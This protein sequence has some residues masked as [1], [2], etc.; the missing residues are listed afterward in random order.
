[1]ATLLH[2]N[3]ATVYS[4]GVDG[5][6]VWYTM[7]YLEGG[8]LGGAAPLRIRDVVET[9][10]QVSRAL[11]HM[12]RR[13]VVHRD[14]KPSNIHLKRDLSGRID[15]ATLFDFGIATTL[16][17]TRRTEIGTF[18][19]TLG[20]SAP[21]LIDGARPSPASDQYALACTAFELL[22]GS[23]PFPESTTTAIVAAHSAAP[24]PPISE[25]GERFAAL[26]AVFHRALAKKPTARYPSCSAFASAMSAALLRETHSIDSAHPSE[27]LPVRRS[28]V[29]PA[30]SRDTGSSP[31]S[32]VSAK[33]YRRRRLIFGGL[34]V[35]IVAFISVLAAAQ[36]RSYTQT[37]ESSSEVS[38][39]SSASS[40]G[41]MG[42]GADQTV[43]ARSSAVRGDQVQGAT[44]STGPSPM[45]T[46]ETGSA[47][48]DQQRGPSE[49]GGSTEPAVGDESTSTNNRVWGLLLDPNGR[50]YAA[51]RFR[52]ADAMLSEVRARWGYDSAT[53]K[54]LYFTEGC[55]AFAAGEP[56]PRSTAQVQ[57]AF[58][59]DRH[60]AEQAAMAKATEALG[61][62]S[63]VVDSLCVDDS[64]GG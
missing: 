34:A 21:E 23:L 6:R 37:G 64:I 11:D 15:R 43:I 19:G 38:A 17:A 45:S 41:A 3:V 40:S 26:D 5:E 58:G 49:P 33:V 62:R 61:V 42:S 1:M 47:A 50:T 55:G 9:I 7:E 56:G 13:G 30:M 25:F 12:H 14:V 8:D 31:R 32:P 60:A 35:L 10:T 22:T 63:F 20:Y 18:V 59:L 53:W 36:I 39:L 2:P 44:P 16:G 54:V 29:S 4:F 51:A 48:G 28:P 24:V 57:S 46:E 52:T 27:P